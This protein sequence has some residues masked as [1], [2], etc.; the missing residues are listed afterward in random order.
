MKIT[1]TFRNFANA[2][3]NLCVVFTDM[4]VARFSEQK[5]LFPYTDLYNEDREC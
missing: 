4:S 3:K 1:R 2:L 5:R